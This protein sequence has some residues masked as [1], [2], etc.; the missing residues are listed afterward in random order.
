MMDASRREFLKIGGLAATQLLSPLGMMSQNTMSQDSVDGQVSEDRLRQRISRSDL[1]YPRPVT[2]S[3][4]G[5]PI[6]NGRMGTL[7]WTTTTKLR[8]QLNRVDVYASN[9]ASNSFV[10]PHNDYCGGCAYLDVDFGSEVFSLSGFQQHLQVYDGRLVI[11]TSGVRLEVF[12]LFSHDV[13][14]IGLTDRRTEP[15]PI[16][17]TLRSL[18]FD[19]KYLAN[20]IEVNSREHASTVQTRN[21]SARTRLIAGDQMIS[22][23][24]EFREGHYIC[25]SGV[26][27]GLVGA[28]GSSEVVNETEVQLRAG[29]Q[30]PSCILIGSAA[31][32]D[33]QED[34]AHLAQAQVDSVVSVD[35]GVL[36]GESEQWWHRFWRLGSLELRSQDGKAEFIQENYHYFLYLMAATSQGKFPAKFNGMLWT[37]GGDFRMW[38]AQHWWTNLSCYYEAVPTSG[39]FDLMNPMFDMYTGMFEACQTAARQEWGSQ[40]IYIPETAYFDG[41]ER[42]PD[43]IA[44]EMRELYLERKPWAERSPAFK[45][46]AT[47]KHPYSPPWNWMAVGHWVEGRWVVHDRGDG[48]YGPC[49]HWITATAKIAYM[50]WR[51]YEYTRDV[52]WLRVRAYPMIRGAVEFYRHHPNVSKSAD[53]KYHVRGTNNGEPVKGAHDATEDLAAMKA[54]TAVLLRAAEVLHADSSMV[55]VW[56]EFLENIAP[57]ATSDSREAIGM[58]NY[59]G[60]RVMVTGLKPVVHP[61]PA[62]LVQDI[63][64]LPT[65]FFDL[66]SVETGDKEMVQLAEATLQEIIRTTPEETVRFGG[67]SKLGV[68]AAALGHTEAVTEFIPKQMKAPPIERSTTYKNA[69][70]LANRMSLLEGA[71]ALGAEHLGRASEALHMALLQSNPPAPGEEPILNCF[72]AWPKAWD[73]SFTLSARGGFTVTASI[74]SGKVRFVEL[75]SNAGSLCRLRNPY[76]TN[77]EVYRNGDRAELLSGSLL[78]FKTTKGERIAIRPHA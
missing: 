36:R 57:L 64:S 41:L 4:E 15:R 30:A 6:G 55:S 20:Q 42:L 39:R 59:H 29:S 66:C 67:L 8:M 60:P 76:S 1:I 2:R 19:P 25:K 56:R 65:W 17:V 53:G 61:G 21:H 31:T 11:E 44:D 71:Q 48:P 37:T 27:V 9:A 63:N 69:A 28:A 70:A 74:E 45:D 18:R 50:F 43:A 46:Y 75:Q 77:V 33:A 38:G 22:L 13:I 68:A 24:Q 54:T 40:G 34:I 52:E 16:S 47:T 10:E 49:S 12:P 3:E 35:P 5:I 7:V 51:R 14:A 62:G 73:A 26:A 32:F 23:N 58:E 78:E 72:P